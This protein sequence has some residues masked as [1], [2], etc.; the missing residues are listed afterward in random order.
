MR[1]DNRYGYKRY[2]L[3]KQEVIDAFNNPYKV[4]WQ[5]SGYGESAILTYEHLMYYLENYQRYSWGIWDIRCYESAK[6][7]IEDGKKYNYVLKSL[8]GY[9]LYKIPVE[10][11]DG[12]IGIDRFEFVSFDNL[13]KDYRWEDG[14]KC[15]IINYATQSISI[16]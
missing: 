4:V 7:F 12:G 2:I 1:E 8:K 3:T 14:R 11:C 16:E 10:V 13:L 15:G 6:E 9:N 5:A